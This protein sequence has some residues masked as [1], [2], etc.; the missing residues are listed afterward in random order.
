[1]ALTIGELADATGTTIETIR[2]YERRGLLRAP[3][4][5]PAGYRQYTD[6]DRWRLRFIQRAKELGF[7]LREIL[8]LT[9]TDQ[10]RSARDVLAAARHKLEEVDAQA[11]ELAVL[12]QSLQR[13]VTACENGNDAE[14]LG[15]RLST[16][17]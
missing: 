2:Y 8:A 12:R 4:R 15:L 6:E 14:C 11:R 16:T 7:T 3:P 10:A 17:P 9:G 1:M 5:T 13:L